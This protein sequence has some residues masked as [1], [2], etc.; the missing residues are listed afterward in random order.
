MSFAGDVKGSE[1][2]A[3]NDNWWK[4]T[5]VNIVIVVPLEEDP[6]TRSRQF[7]FLNQVIYC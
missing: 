5:L 7:S 3:D 2:T 1:I 6:V 4:K